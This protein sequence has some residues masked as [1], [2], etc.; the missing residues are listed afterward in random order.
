MYVKGFIALSACVRFKESG[1]NSL[2]LD[3]SARFLLYVFDELALE[4][5]E[6]K[7]I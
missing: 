4:E 5:S 3:T 2:D 1:P 7:T 6:T